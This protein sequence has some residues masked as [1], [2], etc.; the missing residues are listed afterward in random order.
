MKDSGA[1]LNSTPA[2]TRQGGMLELVECLAKSPLTLSFSPRGEGTP[3]LFSHLG[4]KGRSS[5]PLPL[6]RGLG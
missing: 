5:P 4:K 1:G 3:E 6:G 2:G